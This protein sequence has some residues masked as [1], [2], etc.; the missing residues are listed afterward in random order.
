M[1]ESLPPGSAGVIAVYDHAHAELVDQTLANAIRK[2][3]AQIDKAS[4]KEL[5]GGLAEAGGRIGRL[6]ARRPYAGEPEF[7]GEISEHRQQTEGADRLLHPHEAVGESR[8]RDGGC[9]R[10]AGL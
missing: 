10:G 7:E 2:S 3:T 8:R 4:A 6:K 1:D 9:I 5:K